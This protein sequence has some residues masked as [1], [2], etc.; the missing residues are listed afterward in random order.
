MTF[1]G[2]AFSARKGYWEYAFQVRPPPHGFSHASFSSNTTVLTPLEASCA[3]ANAPEGPPPRIA[4]FMA[5]GWDRPE[6]GL[7]AADRVFRR[8]ERSAQRRD[9]R[10]AFLAGQPRLHGSSCCGP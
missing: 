5:S 3:A 1:F 6:D 2:V 8:Q 7:R 4:T 9:V 10:A